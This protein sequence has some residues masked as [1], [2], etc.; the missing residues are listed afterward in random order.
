MSQSREGVEATELAAQDAATA[1][2][3]INAHGAGSSGNPFGSSRPSSYR[4]ATSSDDSSSC[5]EDEGEMSDA[6]RRRKEK[7]NP[8]IEKKAS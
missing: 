4:G 1:P 6:R 3:V 2:P 8:K 5:N 7:M